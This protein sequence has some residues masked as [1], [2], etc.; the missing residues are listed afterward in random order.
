LVNNFFG[1]FKKALQ[2][3]CAVVYGN[4]SRRQTV[5]AAFPRRRVEQDRKQVSSFLQASISARRLLK[6][7]D[8]YLNKLS[9]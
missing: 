7:L 8:G 5:K 1:F 6:Q 2:K 3:L 9:A 4:F